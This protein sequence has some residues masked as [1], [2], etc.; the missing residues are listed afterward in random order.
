MFSYSS[1]FAFN[2]NNVSLSYEKYDWHMI[3]T[4][5]EIPV[6]IYL[7]HLFNKNNEIIL[8]YFSYY[9]VKTEALVIN[10]IAKRS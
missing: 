4:S 2:L 7:R 10:S 6:H 8:P 9:Y 1:E 3:S 5:N